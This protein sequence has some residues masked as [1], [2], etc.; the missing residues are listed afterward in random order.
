MK[1]QINSFEDA[2]KALNRQPLLPDVS[3]LPEAQGKW[4][5]A[6]VKLDVI[7]EAR[8]NE[9]LPEP[10]IPDY[11]D[12]DQTKYWAVFK[13]STGSGWSCDGY[14]GWCTGS[15]AGARPFR[16]EELEMD[17]VKDFKELY[18]DILDYQNGK[19]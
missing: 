10:W 14:G 11:D 17:T 12:W 18:N 8:N 19:I 16:T 1:T 7:T 15:S 6:T 9:G 4:L 13:F 2:C 3:M 5:I